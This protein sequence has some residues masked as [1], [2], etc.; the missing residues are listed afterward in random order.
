M[1]RCN[2]PG[3]GRGDIDSQGYC[4][5]CGRRSLRDRGRAPGQVRPAHDAAR[6]LPA[7]PEPWWGLGL[8][9]ADTIPPPAQEPAQARGAVPEEARFC[10]NCGHPIG[11][12]RGSAPGRVT[13][14]CRNCGRPFDFTRADAGYVAA[15]RYKIRRKLG[16]GSFGTALLAHDHNLGTDVVL[17]KMAPAD[18]ETARLERDA[19]AG[20]RH[21]SIV[22]I[23]GY[24]PE[25]P[26]LVLEY[27]RGT[28]LPARAYDR[29]E[30][31]LAHGLQILQALDYLH[32]R[33]LLHLDVKPENII[34]F[35]ERDAG[36]SRDRVRLIDFGAVRKLG[37]PRPVTIYTKA[38]APPPADRERSFPT[39]GFDLFCLGTTLRQICRHLPR[40]P[41]DPGIEALDRL[42][43]RA[44][45]TRLPRRRF[46]SARQFAE[47][48][49][50]VIRQVVAVSPARRQVT[51]PSAIFGSMTATLDGGLGKAR[52][53]SHWIT[54]RA[55]GRRG[56]EMA[57]PFAAP[58]P[59]EAVAALPA[60]LADP[61]E[62][63]MTP[64]CATSLA[65]CRAALRHGRPGDAEHALGQARLPEWFWVGAW[66]GGLIGLARGD[67][68][69]ARE[70][71]SAVRDALPGELIPT[72]ALGVCAEIGGDP[73]QADEACHCYKTV[74]DTA[75]ALGAAA[76]GLARAHLLAGRRAEAVDTAERL[77]AELQERELRFEEEARI[78]TVRLLS[79]V[80]DTC[81]PTLA[82]LER[83]RE[84]T[85]EL[86]AA[87]ETLTGLRAEIEY[88]MSTITGEWLALSEMIPE[89]AQSA[90]TKGEFFAM[91]DLASNLRPPV[92]W[93]WQRGFRRIR[94]RPP[95]SA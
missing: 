4:P 25:G 68:P 48:L 21:D 79:A 1:A 57:P 19:L 51:R 18:A 45:D 32:E 53:L 55:S 34:R 7:R 13:G 17:K 3:C 37:S 93:W 95:V 14:F 9:A 33:G 43:A 78:A 82:D 74:A 30:V 87:P 71:F 60:P 12:A 42:L 90:R 41:G 94:D 6:A 83:A 44:T 54:A 72:L 61:D 24:E 84:L 92:E 85:K 31:I 38:Y 88:G 11:R 81:Q 35:G 47:Q 50:G 20:L 80:T 5:A 86:S 39:P 62:P 29:L 76:F 77:A 63:A 40:N 22:R 49:S 28:P 67:A 46:V 69:G 52:P 58:R 36:G 91:I 2:R 64:A 89:L 66:Y 15:G 65:E 26:Y 70:F 10:G 59:G 75:P 27:V 23:Y 8:V 73:D 16:A 56:L